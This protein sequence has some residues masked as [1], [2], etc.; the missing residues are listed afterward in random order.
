[1][2]LRTPLKK[3]QIFIDRS[4]VE[5]FANDGEGNIYHPCLSGGGEKYYTWKEMQW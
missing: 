5:I 4:S 1:M 2:P 3:L